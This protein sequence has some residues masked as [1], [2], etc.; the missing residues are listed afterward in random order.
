MLSAVLMGLHSLLGGFFIVSHD[1]PESLFWLFDSTYLKHAIDGAGSLIFGFDRAK[2]K[3]SETLGQSMIN[4]CH[5]QSTKKF[6]KFLGV[7]ENLS[8]SYSIILITFA[9]LHITTYFI[10]R[11]R[12]K[13]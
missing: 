7:K 12:L 6:M 11:H 13:N 9:L 8:K 1:I 5:F 4:Y 3:C 10:M 2:L